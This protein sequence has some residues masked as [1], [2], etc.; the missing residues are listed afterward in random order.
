MDSKSNQLYYYAR[1][2]DQALKTLGLRVLDSVIP[3]LSLQNPTADDVSLS[4]D[5]LLTQG[6][7]DSNCSIDSSMTRE[8][9]IKYA[10]DMA[11][12]S[13][14]VE[15]SKL[16]LFSFLD[17]RAVD[18]LTRGSMDLSSRK[19]DWGNDTDRLCDSFLQIPNYEELVQLA[20]NGLN[21][22]HSVSPALRK[23]IQDV[24]KLAASTP[25][26]H[27]TA[28]D[29]KVWDK[30]VDYARI[31]GLHPLEATKNDVLT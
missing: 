3:G 24:S 21:V 2:R 5:H 30:F 19:K 29:M 10:L 20:S 28:E 11:S 15:K 13:Q 31:K 6:N 25:T 7:K 16:S 22:Y 12:A 4:F 18:C 23:V 26:P 27:S 1:A 8:E 17:Q 14:L 9:R